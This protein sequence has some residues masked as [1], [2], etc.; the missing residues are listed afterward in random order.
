MDHFVVISGCSGGGN[1]RCLRN[2]TGKAMLL[3]KSLGGASCRKKSEPEVKPYRGST[4]MPFCVG[5]SQ[6]HW[7]TI[8][9][10]GLAAGNGCSLI[11]A[12]LMWHHYHHRVFLAPPSWHAYSMK[13]H[14]RPTNALSL[15]THRRYS[16]RSAWPLC[17][18]FPECL[19]RFLSF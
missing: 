9:M 7:M 8:K 11:D 14:Y 17:G 18:G 12:R 5:P 13:L 19:R 1:P 2:S 4:W 15:K 6:Q 16:E 3:S 10:P